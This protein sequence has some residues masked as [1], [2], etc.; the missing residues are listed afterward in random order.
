M[1][2]PRISSL[3][4][5]R[6]SLTNGMHINGRTDVGTSFA[7]IFAPRTSL[8]ILQ[9]QPHKTQGYYVADGTSDATI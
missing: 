4:A 9:P 6:G 2:A 7:G 8:T 3:L 1:R 5:V